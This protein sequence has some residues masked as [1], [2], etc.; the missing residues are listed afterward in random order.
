MDDG[1]VLG[2]LAVSRAFG[3]GGLKRPRADSV[4]A[5]AAAESG[6]PRPPRLRA[7]PV[8][9]TPDVTLVT[10]GP[11]DE[12]VVV[13]SDGVWDVVSSADAVRVV[14]SALRR[15]AGAPGAAAALA[16]AAAKRRTQ[17][18]VAVV[19]VDLGHGDRG[20]KKGGWGGLFGR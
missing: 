5:A 13:A 17:D 8:V 2:V 14:R 1:R 4:V 6:L 10:T 3:D 16:E 19:V 11:S 18:N 9:P 15:G 7:D 12:F 20:G